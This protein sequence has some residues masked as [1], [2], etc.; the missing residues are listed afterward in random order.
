MYNTIEAAKNKG[1][2][3]TASIMHGYEDKHSVLYR[4]AVSTDIHTFQLVD[5]ECAMSTYKLSKIIH[6]MK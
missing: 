2:D 1:N 4:F 5:N 3:Q 6:L